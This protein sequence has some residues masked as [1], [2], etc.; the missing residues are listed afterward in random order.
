LKFT[1]LFLK[2]LQVHIKKIITESA[3]VFLDLTLYKKMKN[4]QLNYHKA[5]ASTSIVEYRWFKV[6]NVIVL[7]ALVLIGIFNLTF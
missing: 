1:V 6:L 4:V 7:S 5:K 2:E 3:P